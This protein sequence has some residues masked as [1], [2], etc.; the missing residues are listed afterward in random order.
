M[1]Q[2]SYISLAYL[3]KKLSCYHVSARDMARTRRRTAASGPALQRSPFPPFPPPPPHFPPPRSRR[4]RKRSIS[5]TKSRWRFRRRKQR[6][7]RLVCGARCGYSR[8]SMIQHRKSYFHLA[9]STSLFLTPYSF[10]CR[11]HFT[12]GSSRAQKTTSVWSSS[13][14]ESSLNASERDAVAVLWYVRTVFNYR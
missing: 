6:E 9:P 14:A 12:S 4:R 2:S 5:R 8:A 11:S 13:W 1:C 7:T 3:H 10:C